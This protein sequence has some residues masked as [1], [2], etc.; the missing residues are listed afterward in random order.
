MRF[1]GCRVALLGAP[2]AAPLRGASL[3]RLRSFSRRFAVLGVATPAPHTPPCAASRLR[4]PLRFAGGLGAPAPADCPLG[5][6]AR[7]G[8]RPLLAAPCSVAPLLGL[9]PSRLVRHFCLPS[10]LCVCARGCSRRGSVCRVFAAAVS[11]CGLRGSAAYEGP[12]PMTVCSLR[13]L[14]PYVRTLVGDV[15]KDLAFLN[16]NASLT[17]ARPLKPFGARVHSGLPRELARFRARIASTPP[18]YPPPI[19]RGYGRARGQTL[20]ALGT[21][22]LA[23]SPTRPSA[24]AAAR[25]SLRGCS[26]RSHSLRCALA[27]ATLHT[28]VCALRPPASAR[29]PAKPNARPRALGIFACLGTLRLSATH[30]FCPLAVRNCAHAHKSR[31]T[32]LPRAFAACRALRRLGN[33]LLLFSGMLSRH[34]F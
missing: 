28:Q 6:S 27:A 30:L 15:S 11:L 10:G 7:W 17:R 31:A 32:V 9:A 14:S 1:A 33:R 16:T 20:C 19:G 26:L 13:S 8:L 18:P 2:A 29:K 22:R 21:L 25:F 12:C 3:A 34:Q 5:W 4:S 23:P 24:F